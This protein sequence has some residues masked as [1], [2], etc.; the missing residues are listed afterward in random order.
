V[1]DIFMF[2]IPVALIQTI[3]LPPRRKL[4]LYMV[5]LPGVLYGPSLYMRSYYQS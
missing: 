3:A 4:H 2:V 5:L 1:C